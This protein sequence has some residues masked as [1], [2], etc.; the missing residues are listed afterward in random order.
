MSRARREPMLYK[1]KELMN[2]FNNFCI[3]VKIWAVQ[4]GGT[5]EQ[6]K[7]IEGLMN[8]YPKFTTEEVDDMLGR[9]MEVLEKDAEPMIKR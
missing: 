2:D 8:R 9:I 4:H 7:Q 6:R 5:D 3:K 1:N